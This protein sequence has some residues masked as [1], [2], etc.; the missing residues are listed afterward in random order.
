MLPYA[1]PA[2]AQCDPR[3][4]AGLRP[5]GRRGGEP[6]PVRGQ[7]GLGPGVLWAGRLHPQLHR[8]RHARWRFPRVLG[9][10]GRA[11]RR[12]PP[13][14]PQ[15]HLG[16]L[17]G[18]APPGLRRPRVRVGCHPAVPLQP[19]DRF[20]RGPGAAE[21]PH[22]LQQGP[23]HLAGRRLQDLAGVSNPPWH[24]GRRSPRL[25]SLQ[26]S[27]QAPPAGLPRPPDDQQVRIRGAQRRD[28]VAVLPDYGVIG[29]DRPG[30][31]GVRPGPL[32]G[33]CSD[34]Q[35]QPD[36]PLAP[37]GDDLGGVLHAQARR[38]KGGIR[39]VHHGGDVA[40][41]PTGARQPSPQGADREHEV[42]AGR[43]SRA[44][45]CDVLPHAALSHVQEPPYGRN[46]GFSR[47]S[48]AR[49]C[50]RQAARHGAAA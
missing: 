41:G 46:R 7:L 23:G 5:P 35:V 24:Y 19:P 26:V 39:E 11:G 22:G 2:P 34:L 25:A 6:N 13:L 48:G 15:R 43:H 44:V 36:P 40:G 33:G 10:G 28:D 1:Q 45:P 9:R 49:G 8:G 47:R 29:Q 20:R 16:L 18:R 31:V 3:L 27:Q 38:A 14:R 4:G 12:L 42:D 21:N 32:A 37:Q 50:R 17:L 30:R